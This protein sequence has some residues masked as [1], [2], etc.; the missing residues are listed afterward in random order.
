MA[1]FV[2]GE[3]PF[4]FL[5]V[6]VIRAHAHQLD[7]SALMILI[8]GGSF[9]HSFVMWVKILRVAPCSLIISECL[10]I[11]EASRYVMLVLE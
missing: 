1:R 4:L 6:V 9:V 8:L 10:L 2:W 7:I 5:F 11:K 3:N